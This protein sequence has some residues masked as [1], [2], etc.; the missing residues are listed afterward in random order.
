M[1]RGD[2]CFF[3]GMAVQA[4]KVRVSESAERIASPSWCL[5]VDTGLPGGTATERGTRPSTGEGG[6]HLRRPAQHLTRYWAQA[7]FGPELHRKHAQSR[8][9]AELRTF[10]VVIETKHFM[11]CA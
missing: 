2:A 6:R 8:I 10:S 5:I 7:E 3:A 11:P 1:I 9:K 4:V